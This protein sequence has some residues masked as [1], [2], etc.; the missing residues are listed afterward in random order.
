MHTTIIEL[1]IYSRHA[2]RVPAAPLS[3]YVLRG[4]EDCHEII[5]HGSYAIVKKLRFRGLECVGKKMHDILYINANPQ[6]QQDMLSR[7]EGEC[8]LL[9]QIMHPCIVQFMGVYFEDDTPLPVLVMEC[10][11]S[12]LASVLDQH[13]V[14]ADQISYGI[15]GDVC[16]G[17]R[18]LHERSPPI[19]HRDLSANNVLLTINMNAKISDL[20]VAKILNAI[21]AGMAPMV[22]T[23]APGT[24]CY[25]PPE[26]MVSHPQYNTKIDIYSMGVMLLH[27]LSGKWP[28]PTD[29]FRPDP[30]NPNSM[31]P[32]TE[33]ERRS[34]H[35]RKVGYGHP[36]ASLIIC[37]LSNNQCIRPHAAQLHARLLRVRSKDPLEVQTRVEI[38]QQLQASQDETTALTERV[39][40]LEEEKEAILCLHSSQR[41]HK[42]V[43][44]A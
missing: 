2:D 6:Q 22:Q 36:L 27:V 18:Y 33:V 29:A 40:A 14:L 23:K 12:T 26:A 21:P 25:M 24:P 11:H 3:R 8:E 7:F 4:V 30:A 13:G 15:L 44:V 35:L 31:L 5:G 37:C 34:E 17:L 42:Q 43:M 41:S 1:I 28:F 16:L 19:I 39:K 32:V 9:S 20:G 38:M 10:L